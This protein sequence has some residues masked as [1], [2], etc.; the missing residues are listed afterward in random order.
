MEG[1]GSKRGGGDLLRIGRRFRKAETVSHDRSKAYFAKQHAKREERRRLWAE[2]RKGRRLAQVTLMRKYRV[3]ELPDVQITAGEVVKALRNLCARDVAAARLVMLHLGRALTAKYP[4][5]K[6]KLGE[7]LRNALVEESNELYDRTAAATL[8]EL[9]RTCCCDHAPMSDGLVD[10]V[11]S[12][13]MSLRLEPLGVLLLEAHVAADRDGEAAPSAKRRREENVGGGSELRAWT[14]MVDLYKSMGDFDSARG[15]MFAAGEASEDEKR[16]KLLSKE[17]QACWTAARDISREL[18]KGRGGPEKGAR[19]RT[20]WESHLNA[21]ESLSSWDC[22]VEEMPPEIAAEPSRILQGEWNTRFLLPKLVRAETHNMVERPH[23]RN[24]LFPMVESCRKEQNYF[25]HFRQHFG[26]ELTLMYLLKGKEKDARLSHDTTVSAFLAEWAATPFAS[27]G[28]EG[29]TK[30]KEQLARLRRLS[31]MD[32]A[33]G[34]FSDG[35]RR[36]CL[37]DDWTSSELQFAGYASLQECDDLVRDR[38]VQARA[39]VAAGLA[40][41]ETVEKVV[42]CR[43]HLDLARESNLRRQ[44]EVAVN[45]LQLAKAD[46]TSVTDKDLRRRYDLLYADTVAVKAVKSPEA[47]LPTKFNA[48]YRFLMDNEDKDDG[49]SAHGITRAKLLH[50]LEE[51]LTQFEPSTTLDDLSGLLSKEAKQQHFKDLSKGASDLEGLRRQILHEVCGSMQNGRGGGGGG[52]TGSMDG[53]R[54]M[55]LSAICYRLLKDFGDTG[56]AR[57]LVDAHL[58]AISMGSNRARQLFPNLMEAAGGM[59]D[60]TLSV[61]EE[62]L[63]EVE[64]WLF[65]PWAN[66]LISLALT[67]KGRRGRI[68]KGLLLRMAKEYPEALKFPYLVSKEASGG[69]MQNSELDSVLSLSQVQ[70]KIL[71]GLS[72][73]SL[74]AGSPSEIKDPKEMKIK[75]DGRGR[76]FFS[77]SLGDYVPLLREFHSVG[78]GSMEIPGQYSGYQRPRPERHVRLMCFHE[79][80]KVFSSLR[81]P[82]LVGL[83]GN[84]GSVYR[85]IVKCGE[86]LRQDERIEQVFAVANRLVLFPSSVTITAQD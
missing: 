85:F 53:D 5:E 56:V 40:P 60:E 42:A 1:G 52:A 59:D 65:L 4:E 22:L 50:A 83:V 12:L 24:V 58:K 10:T 82:V 73:L 23:R 79:K 57:I 47:A 69:E 64:P 70:E 26:Q 67:S 61:M 9:C 38:T 34:S 76:R 41:D 74:P 46:L 8:L 29:G 45:I 39:L 13:C 3:G 77:D 11:A 71:L 55:E 81:K 19:T 43:G 49:S 20:L 68:W 15:A 16:A 33:I 2:E 63:G 84:D 37:L 51:L 27:A 30:L 72:R 44:W 35:G 17:S 7:V 75:V 62:K 48:L 36:T 18:L 86:D 31:Q 80:V 21:L 78:G 54:W 25:D 66:Q 28:E 6:S 32:L 14:A